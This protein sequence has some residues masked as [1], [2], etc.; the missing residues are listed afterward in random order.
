MY[1]RLLGVAVRVD[2]DPAA[3]VTRGLCQLQ[4]QSDA[5]MWPDISISHADARTLYCKQWLPSHVG[6]E[7]RRILKRRHRTS[8]RSRR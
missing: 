8:N 4:S 7:K 3:P 6:G 2:V 1:D 5:G